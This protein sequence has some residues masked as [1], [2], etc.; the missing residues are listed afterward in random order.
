MVESM[1][2]GMSPT[3]AAEDAIQTI[4]QYYPDF[5]GALVAVNIS[6]DYGAASHGFKTFTYT[7]YNPALGNSTVVNL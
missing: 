7:V 3:A 6:G 1:R 4:A 2:R 5:S